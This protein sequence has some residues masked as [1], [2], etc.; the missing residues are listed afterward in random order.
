MLRLDVKKLA[1]NIKEAAPVSEEEAEACRFLFLL[2]ERGVRL[3]EFRAGTLEKVLERYYAGKGAY[4]E[5]KLSAF[6]DIRQ[7]AGK[8][9]GIV[10]EVRFV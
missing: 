3:S 2:T 6:R 9:R 5:A 7:T 4:L 10:D 8:A 1:Q